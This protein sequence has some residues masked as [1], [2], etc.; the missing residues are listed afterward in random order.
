MVVVKVKKRHFLSLCD[1]G[2]NSTGECR[3]NLADLLDV[4]HVIRLIRPFPL[5]VNDS[6]ND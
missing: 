5:P 6:R 4:H 3:T 2:G 1:E